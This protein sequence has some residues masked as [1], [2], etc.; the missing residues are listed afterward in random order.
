[1]SS[2]AQDANDLL[3]TLVNIRRDLHQIPEFGLHLPKTQQ[4]LLDQI[5]DLGEI[6][7]GKDLSSIVLTIDSGAPGPTVLL[8]SDMDGLAVEEQN[9]LPYKSTNG[10]MHACGHDLHMASAIGAAKLIH[11]RKDQLVGK[12]VIWFQPG[13]EGHGGADLMIEEG[14]LS[15]SGEMPIAA[16]GLHVFTSIPHGLFTTKPGALMAS[17]GGVVVELAG[18]GGHG[19]MPWL[20]KDPIAAA[21]EVISSLQQFVTKQFSALDPVIINVGWFHAGDQSTTN[22]IPESASFGVTIRT[23][24]KQ[25]YEQVI[26]TLPGFIESIA[27]AHQVSAKIRFDP[28]SKVVINDPE[29]FELSKK[30]II[31]CFGED[32]FL[33]MT[34]PI[35]GG[36]DF[37]SILEHVPGTFAFLGSCPPDI[38]HET[39]ST[40]HSSKAI[41][42]DS[43]VAYGAAWLASMAISHLSK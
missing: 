37:S 17:A 1:M 9:D 33:E 32:R 39:A 12:V 15:I 34:E 3:P 5:Q 27:G 29:K 43:V 38:N 10:F 14:A 24:S 26:R 4:Y 30:V 11:Q 21:V 28:A 36:E 41:F 31:D 6:S 13:E 40:N 8:R 20:A 23:F 7:L 22:V 25:S 42:D 35:T 19:S 16:Y 2:I 18:Q